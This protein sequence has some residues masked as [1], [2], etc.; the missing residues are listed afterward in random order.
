MIFVID[1][2][3]GVRE[4]TASLLRS[5]GYEVLTFD[6][7][8]SFLEANERGE[9]NSCAIIDIVMPDIDG[10][11]LHRR[12]VSSGHRFPIIF[13]TALTDAATRARMT[14]C[15]VHRV[16]TKPCSEQSLV[17]CVE[18]ALAEAGAA[19]EQRPAR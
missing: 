11:E 17:D 7:G 14:E 12:L 10:F 13:L 4:G 18:S 1:D 9:S 2:D 3:I 6:S 19:T 16:L 5:L 15:G 8:R